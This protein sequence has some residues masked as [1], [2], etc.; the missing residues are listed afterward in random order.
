MPSRVL[1]AEPAG[2]RFATGADRTRALARGN[3]LHRLMQSLPEIPPERRDE[4]ARRFLT[5]RRGEF[6]DTECDALAKQALAVLAA[7]RF[8]ALFA[9]GSRAEVPIVGR[10][11]D[12]TVSSVVDRLAVTADAVLIADYKTNRPP[13]RQLEEVPQAYIAQLALYRAVLSRL[14]PGRPVRAALVW[15][16]VPDLMEIPGAALDAARAAVTTS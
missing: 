12:A 11:G 8:A 14:Y 2:H 5:R 13:P 16:E 6:T 10:V 7:P 1:E 4:A 15:T 9:P 3:L